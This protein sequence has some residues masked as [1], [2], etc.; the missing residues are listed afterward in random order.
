MSTSRRLN[1]GADL[2]VLVLAHNRRELTR[3]CLEALA[4]SHWP[5]SAE[6]VLVDNASTDDTASLVEEFRTRVP[7]LS[8]RSFAR[9]LTFSTANNRAAA[10]TSGSVVVF[11]NN[12]VCVDATCWREIWARFAEDASCAVVGARLRY[13]AT[14]RVQH[15]GMHQML[16]GYASNYGVGGRVRDRRW[17]CDQDVFAVTG[18]LMA[19]RR[20]RFEGVGGFDDGFAWGY[21]DVDLCQRVRHAG[22]RVVYVPSVEGVHHESATFPTT[23]NRRHFGAN[24]RRFRQRWNWWLAPRERA[25]VEHLRRQRI[26][27]VA[28]YGM[29]SAARGLMRTL[30]RHGIRVEA[31]TASVV[32]AGVLTWQGCR[33]VSREDAPRLGVDKL[34][35]GTQAYFGIEIDVRRASPDGE[36]LVPEIAA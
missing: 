33:V 23:S 29:G 14:S 27:R 8:L 11:L 22:G 26:R 13:P 32:P 28:V 7:C 5:V 21:E 16:W 1:L 34:V 4:S 18:A 36:P 30:A 25:Y 15:A 35:V 9:N 31:V 10:R 2:S 6:V 17:T 24:Y 19:V 3:A 12:D 20:A